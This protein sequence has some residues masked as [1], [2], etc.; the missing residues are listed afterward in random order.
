[1]NPRKHTTSSRVLALTTATLPTLKTL[2]TLPQSSASKLFAPYT[3]WL[4]RETSRPIFEFIVRAFGGRIGW[5]ATSGSG[6]PFDETDDSI[7]HV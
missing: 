7:T 2:S 4:S 5:P 1:M 6:S 3:F